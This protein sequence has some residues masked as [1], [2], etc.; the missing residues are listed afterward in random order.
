MIY[1]SHSIEETEDHQDKPSFRTKRSLLPEIN[2]T[3]YANNDSNES[4][5][6]PA[7]GAGTDVINAIYSLVTLSLI[8]LFE[9]GFNKVF[10]SDHL[11]QS[12]GNFE[13]SSNSLE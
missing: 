2:M 13:K 4:K 9:S 7:L 10:Y 8:Y 1:Y 11:M 5:S 6:S 12:L 3:H